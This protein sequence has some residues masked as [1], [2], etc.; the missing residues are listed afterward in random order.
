MKQEEI[1]FNKVNSLP[2]CHL[3]IQSFTT[4]CDSARVLDRRAVSVSVLTLCFR[5][6]YKVGVERSLKI[7]YKCPELQCVSPKSC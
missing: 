4:N 6:K 5:F 1:Q 3:L 7:G 2:R